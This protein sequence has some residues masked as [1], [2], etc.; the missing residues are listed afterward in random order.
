VFG[1]AA[2]DCLLQHAAARMTEAAPG[3]FVARLGGDEF[4]VI[5]TDEPQPAGAEALANR[6]L[7]ALAGEIDIDGRQLR[8]SLSIGIALYPADGADAPSLLANADAALYRTKAQGRGAFRFFEA[9]MDTHLRERRMLQ[10]E[11]RTALE[12]DELLIHYQPQA[13]MDGEVTGFEALLRW[14]HPTR[15]LVPP[16]T[17]VPL[18]EESGLI[19]EIGEWVLREACREAATWGRPLKIGINLSTVQFQHG[20]LPTTVHGILLETGLSPSRL[21]LEITESVLI[22]DFART[23]SILRRLKALGVRIAMDDFG[24]PATPRSPICSRSRST[25]SRSTARSSPMSSATLSRR[26]SCARSSGWRRAS[27]SR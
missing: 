15:G 23:V 12:N 6:L 19:I 26:R 25:R 27:T 14:Q 5:L 16:T 10:Q 4:T 7:E 8:A 11:L 21:E 17:F 20:D 3:A 2:G 24:A 22:G 18:A 9:N 13:Q 1:H